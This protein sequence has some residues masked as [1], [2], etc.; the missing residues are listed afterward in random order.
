[1]NK[2]LKFAIIMG[3]EPDLG[4]VWRVHRLASALPAAAAQRGAEGLQV[5]VGVHIG[6]QEN[7]TVEALRLPRSAVVR[8]YRWQS[9]ASDVARRMFPTVPFVFTGIDMVHLPR[10]WGWNFTDCDAWIICPD[11]HIGAI[12]PLKPI[13]LYGRDLVDRY[14]PHAAHRRGRV[15]DLATQVQS[16]ISWR[17]AICLIATHPRTVDDYVS[18]AGIRRHKGL[19]LETGRPADPPPDV[20]DLY[21]DEG[22]TTILCLWS[23]QSDGQLV[24]LLRAFRDTLRANPQANVLFAVD[25]FRDDR[26]TALRIELSKH[27]ETLNILPASRYAIENFDTEDDLS[28]LILQCRLVVSPN[29]IPGEPEDLIRSANLDR[30]Y[31]GPGTPQARALAESWGASAFFY[32][33]SSCN[34]LRASIEAAFK[35]ANGSPARSSVGKSESEA[36]ITSLGQL[37][38][39]FEEARGVAD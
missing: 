17:Q 2:P 26:G 23:G 19:V 12:I 3:P 22:S 38:D 4:W 16:L 27:L 25:G 24:P 20:R 15:A 29:G 30:S 33:D 11:V 13:I 32:E 28:R 8:R 14:D 35:A 5:A 18:Y 10:D 21:N 1:M 37:L 6:A 34:T 7:A 9:V 31:V 39:R 36:F